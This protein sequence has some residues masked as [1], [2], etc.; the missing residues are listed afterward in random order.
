MNNIEKQEKLNL[1]LDSIGDILSKAA[2]EIAIEL[3]S[4]DEFKPGSMHHELVL[5]RGNK[6]KF[7]KGLHTPD[8]D[9]RNYVWITVKD[10][11][12]DKKRW[13]IALNF[14]DIDNDRDLEINSG[15]PHTQFGRIQ[16]WKEL[17]IKEGC[18]NGPHVL[19]DKEGGDIALK[20]CGNKSFDPKQSIYDGTYDPKVLVDKFLYNFVY[21]ERTKFYKLFEMDLSHAKYTELQDN[22][23]MHLELITKFKSV[24]LE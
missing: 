24:S 1:A 11:E 19:L 13:M 6:G 5:R 23:D 14:Q 18:C 10:I 12:D 22:P 7:S 9:F 17:N 8:F 3:E 16:F 2:L 20:F 4:R 21:F 15:N